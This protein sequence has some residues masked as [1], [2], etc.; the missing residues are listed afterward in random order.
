MKDRKATLLANHGLICGG[1]NLGEAL[2]ITDQIEFCCRLYT[3]FNAIGYTLLFTE[4]DINLMIDRF[5]NYGKRME[6]HEEI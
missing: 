4:G 3:Q 2:A 6:E 5:K 1:G